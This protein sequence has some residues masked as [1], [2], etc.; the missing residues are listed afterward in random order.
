MDATHPPTLAES[1]LSDQTSQS[2]VE[3]PN[4][5]LEHILWYAGYSTIINC[6][7]TCRRIKGL[8]SGS[9]RLQY[10]IGLSAAGLCDN[11]TSRATT[12]ERFEMLKHHQS[13]WNNSKWSRLYVYSHPIRDRWLQAI[14]G[15]VIV[16]PGEATL[17]PTSLLVNEM[18]SPSRHLEGREWKLA[19]GFRIVQFR[20]DASQ[21]LLI[22]R[23][24]SEPGP[25]RSHSLHV[26]SLSSGEV[27]KSAQSYGGVLTFD[28]AELPLNASLYD[29]CG[30]HFGSRGSTMR[31]H[32][33]D[34]FTVWNWKTGQAVVNYAS[35]NPSASFHPMLRFLD[36]HSALLGFGED[37]KNPGVG[38]FLRVGSFAPG[39]SAPVRFYTFPLPKGLGQQTTTIGHPSILHAVVNSDATPPPTAC[40]ARAGAAAAGPFHADP[41]ERLLSLQLTAFYHGSRTK[42]IA[43]HMRTRAL[44]DA[45]A[46]HAHAGAGTVPWAAWGPAGARFMGPEH[47]DASHFP[48]EPRL[49]GMRAVAGAPAVRAD[50]VRCVA[51]VD[52]HP[53][54]SRRGP[55]AGASGEEWDAAQEGA[56]MPCAV[57]EVPLPHELQYARNPLRFKLCEDALVV[58]EMLSEEDTALRAYAMVV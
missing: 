54:R 46:A 14:S 22:V 49:A 13:Y 55:R 42:R 7:L 33:R 25:Q 12:A 47:C 23:Q 24:Q 31:L 56:R 16:S 9:I 35:E 21:D 39:G 11:P 41:A 10:E 48:A 40:G 38:L 1:S 51:L 3:L 50:G 26:L 2:F 44:L 6:Q 36:A 28:A 17:A 18:P 37:R 53:V 30:D 15:N 19:F 43:L 57:R 5:L 8:V 32:G 52:Y 20:V 27:H 45:I 4:E 29:I 58:Q 34:R